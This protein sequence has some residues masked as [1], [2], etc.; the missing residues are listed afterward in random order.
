MSYNPSGL[1]PLLARTINVL[2]L[3]SPPTIHLILQTM[4]KRSASPGLDQVNSF[5]IQFFPGGV[6]PPLS[7][8][9]ELPGAVQLFCTFMGRSLPLCDKKRTEE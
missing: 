9:G 1:V 5:R 4:D 2:D 6:I 7:A 3:I 8:A